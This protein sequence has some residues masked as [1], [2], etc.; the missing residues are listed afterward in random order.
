MTGQEVV[1]RMKSYSAASGY[2][3]QY[4]FRSVGPARRGFAPGNEY[5]YMVTADR[6]TLFPVRIFIR[7]DALGQWSR[8]HGRALTGTEEYALAKLRL[9]DAFDEVEDFASARPDL[10][11]DSSN[12]E[13]L[14]EKLDV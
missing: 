6:K 5:V 13:A 8:R 10:E 11:V 2:V 14:L 7:S 1:R 3:Y 9:F 12:L 4:F